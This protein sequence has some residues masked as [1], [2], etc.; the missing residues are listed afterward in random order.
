[1]KKNQVEEWDRN[2]EIDV[3]IVRRK[4]IGEKTERVEGGG[5]KEEENAAEHHD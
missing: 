5:V 1:M 2:N 4:I 3:Q